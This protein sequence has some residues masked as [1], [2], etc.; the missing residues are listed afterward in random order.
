M[1]AADILLPIFFFGGAA[2]VLWKFFDTR[3]R[4]RMAMIEKGLNP[5]DFK[6]AGLTEWMRSNPLSSLKWGM[7][8]TF[9]GIG[10][11]AATVIERKADFPDAVYPAS[12]LI[13]G[14]LALVIFYFIAASKSKNDNS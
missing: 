3:H 12:I 4:E 8:A 1:N 13:S 2:L 7:L 5:T 6:K 10:I 9:V 11:F 14:G